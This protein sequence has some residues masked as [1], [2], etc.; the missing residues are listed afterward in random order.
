MYRSVTTLAANVRIDYETTKKTALNEN[1][2][3]GLTSVCPRETDGLRRGV[4]AAGH[5]DLGAAHLQSH[6]YTWSSVYVRH[7]VRIT[8]HPG[9]AQ[10]VQVLY[11]ASP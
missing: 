1:T 7:G 6:E 9:I 4:S 3:V 5:L 2:R 8:G 10:P 11:R